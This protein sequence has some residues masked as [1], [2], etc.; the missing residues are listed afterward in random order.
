[1]RRGDALEQ[2]LEDQ[3]GNDRFAILQFLVCELM[4]KTRIDKIG[5]LAAASTAS[6]HLLAAFSLCIA[7]DENHL[8]SP[9]LSI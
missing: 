7:D 6:D 4:A 2:R 3:V 1:M 5:A 8:F 9:D